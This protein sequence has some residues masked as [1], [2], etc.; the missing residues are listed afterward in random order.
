[1]V[2]LAD[3]RVGGSTHLFTLEP[4]LDLLH[5]SPLNIRHDTI[6]RYLL[7]TGP[8]LLFGIADVVSVNDTI[9][10]KTGLADPG[11]C[12]SVTSIARRRQTVRPPPDGPVFNRN[13]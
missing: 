1:M 13:M 2:Q 5:P 12:V 6:R 3:R 9:E 11:L 10:Q 4:I 7:S 8:R